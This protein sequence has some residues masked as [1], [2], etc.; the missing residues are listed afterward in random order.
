MSQGR[1][2]VKAGQ[3]PGFCLSV[4]GEGGGKGG[5]TS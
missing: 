2:E 1:A 3:G 5:K 4:A